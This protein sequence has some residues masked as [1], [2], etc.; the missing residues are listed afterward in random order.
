VTRRSQFD[1]DDWRII[2]VGVLLLLGAA[3]PGYWALHPERTIPEFDSVPW[4]LLF[5]G[6]LALG[7]LLI[8]AWPFGRRLARGLIF[9]LSFAPFLTAGVL[10][11][12]GV[13]GLALVVLLASWIVLS[14]LFALLAPSLTRAQSA[15]SL[16][17]VLA[18][19]F[20]IVHFGNSPRR[21]SRRPS[22]SGH[23]G[24]DATPTTHSG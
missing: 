4:R 8:R 7:L 2:G 24:R 11:A 22:A 10:L 15:L 5:L 3:A 16:A 20:G 17:A 6:S 13:R 21:R 19:W 14:G 12:K 9:A 18:G 23:R 1:T